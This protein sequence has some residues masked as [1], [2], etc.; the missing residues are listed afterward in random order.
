M[1]TYIQICIYKDHTCIYTYESYIQTYMHTLYI[2][3]HTYIH[4]YIHI[5]IHT[6]VSYIHIHTYGYIHTY[7]Q[8]YGS[9]KSCIRTHIYTDNSYVRTYIQIIHTHTHTHTHTWQDAHFGEMACI[10]QSLT[11]LGRIVMLLSQGHTKGLPF[12]ESKLT[13]L[14]Q[15]KLHLQRAAGRFCCTECA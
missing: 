2:Y 1:R 3:I 10:N 13:R 5:Y 15:V 9:Y 8:T 14:L 6:S 4:I 7:P 11:T 12:R